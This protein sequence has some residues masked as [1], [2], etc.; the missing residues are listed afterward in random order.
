M[1]ARLTAP[2]T[3]HVASRLTLGYQPRPPLP[4]WV[5][6]PPL[7]FLDRPLT[8]IPVRLT[9]LTSLI[10]LESVLFWWLT[11]VNNNAKM[12]A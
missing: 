9:A 12:P 4:H 3:A 11:A 1:T 10:C 2:Y 5:P 6:Y 7:E 8:F